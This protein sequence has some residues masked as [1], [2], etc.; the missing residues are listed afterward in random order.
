MLL[1][2]EIKFINGIGYRLEKRL[3]SSTNISNSRRNVRRTSKSNVLSNVEKLT[4]LINDH[5]K[6]KD[7]VDKKKKNT[8]KW[9]RKKMEWKL[10]NK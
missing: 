6:Y 1:N 4:E 7:V 9:R 5:F 3:F 10:W 2:S 8:Q